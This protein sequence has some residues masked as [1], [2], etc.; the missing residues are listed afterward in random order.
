MSGVGQRFGQII[1]F[2]INE[3]ADRSCMCVEISIIFDN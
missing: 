3:G 2:Q 1:E